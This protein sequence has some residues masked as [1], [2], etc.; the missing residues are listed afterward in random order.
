MV[1]TGI[2]YHEKE[3]KEKSKKRLEYLLTHC[4][5]PKS[6]KERDKTKTG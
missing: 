2:H 4:T 5:L 6:K 3:K 1:E